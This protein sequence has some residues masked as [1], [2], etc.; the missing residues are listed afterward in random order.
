MR[1]AGFWRRLL[2]WVIDFTLWLALV[3][4]L[5]KLVGGGIRRDN[6]WLVFTVEPGYAAANLSV[7][8]G[9]LY[10][11]GCESSAWQATLG[12]RLVGLAVTDE[13]G[14]RISFVRASCRH[15]SKLLSALPLGIGFLITPFTARK[16]ALHDLISHSLVVDAREV[17]PAPVETV[18]LGSIALVLA[19]T[20]LFGSMALISS[21][22]PSVYI[23]PLGHLGTSN[24]QTI[25]ADVSQGTD[26]RVSVLKGFDLPEAVNAQRQQVDAVA[27][28]AALRDHY[29]NLVS[30]G[31][32]II[33]VTTE[34]MYT[35]ADPRWQFVFSLAGDYQVAV[36]SLARMAQ[37]DPLVVEARADTMVAR[38]I[39]VL[40]YRAPL[41]NDPKSILFANVRSVDDIDRMV[42]WPDVTQLS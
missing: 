10:C 30:H 6:G 32:V 20:A 14:E 37:A 7:L 33:G 40:H 2:A 42:Y 1:Y 21:P 34:D 4:A 17:V 12:K 38:E 41:V 18:R 29:A 15:L 31:K 28:D 26:V 11:A 24:A 23:V 5:G 9:W 19:G 39:G 36:V 16:Q 8:I 25:A 27:L 13:N 3:I 22:S 35:S